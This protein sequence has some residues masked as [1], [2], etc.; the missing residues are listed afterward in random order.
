MHNRTK[1]LL[2]LVSLLPLCAQAQIDFFV[3]E[4]SQV[5]KQTAA[6]KL[7]PFGFHSN[8]EYGNNYLV[9]ASIATSGETITNAKLTGP[10]F[11]GGEL[12]EYWAEDNEY[13]IEGEVKTLAEVAALIT[14]GT[15]TFSGTGNTVGTFSE[16][17]TYPSYSPLTPLKITN[18]NDLQSFDV[19][20]PLTIEWEEFTEGQG[21]G[22]SAG[23]GGFIDIEVTGYNNSGGFYWSSEPF[24]PEGAFGFLPTRTSFTFPANTFSTDTIYQVNIWFARID[25]ASDSSSVDGALV[26]NLTGYEVECNFYPQG[27][28]AYWA[29][30]PRSQGGEVNTFFTFGWLYMPLAPW[31]WSDKLNNWIFAYEQVASDGGW[32]Y[33]HELAEGTESLGLAMVDGTDFGYSSVLEKWLY[34]RPG[35]LEAGSGWVNMYPGN[36]F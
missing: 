19:T 10:S 24:H 9:W 16:S 31:V 12:L 8:Y 11:P 21:S 13:G 17:I 26:A 6:T 33:F 1:I 15:Y 5:M 3:G 4:Y 32:V 28:G 34:V 23:Y 14:P 36:F 7:V 18:F 20:Q 30:F 35:G 29:G 27:N 25:Q 22:I 2:L